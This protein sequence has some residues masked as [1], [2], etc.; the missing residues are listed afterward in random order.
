MVGLSHALH[1]RAT[2]AVGG[3]GSRSAVCTWCYWVI[4]SGGQHP[5][6]PAPSSGAGSS[7]VNVQQLWEVRGNSSCGGGLRAVVAAL[8][9]QGGR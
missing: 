6:R 3:E 5:W 7:G 1:I 8:E 2:A 9:A 4:C